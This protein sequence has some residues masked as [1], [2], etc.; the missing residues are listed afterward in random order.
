MNAVN[1][2]GA[3]VV[4]AKTQEEYH[5][6]PVF[7]EQQ[8]P[9]RMV[10]GY[11]LNDEEL[12]Y[13]NNSRVVYGLQV[14]FGNKFAP[15]QM[16]IHPLVNV[17]ENFE[18]PDIED[19]DN[20]DVNVGSLNDMAISLNRKL[21]ERRVWYHQ[22]EKEGHLEGV[23]DVI[24]MADCSIQETEGLAKRLLKKKGIEIRENDMVLVVIEVDGISIVN[25]ASPV[26]N[27]NKG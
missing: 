6:L 12:E 16:S 13:L 19:M 10:Y 1:F 26:E 7:V 5:N 27:Q 18:Q 2:K 23:L 14:T 24:C 11:S 17:P 20:M 22:V 25:G 9:F 21:S 15:V 4:L 8:Y 3:N